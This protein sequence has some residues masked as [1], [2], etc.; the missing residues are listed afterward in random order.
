MNA[1]VSR[2]Q[3]GET[4]IIHRS[5][6]HGADYNPRVIDDAARK[7]LMKAIKQDGLI[8]P[9]V[10]NERTG[11]LVSG[12]QRLGILDQLEKSQDYALSVTV[13]DV[14]ERKEKELNVKFN[15][16]SMQGDWDVEALA[17]LVADDGIGFEE[18]GFTEADAQVLL[19]GDSRLSEMFADTEEVKETKGKLGDIKKERKEATERLKKEQSADFMVTLVCEDRDQKL[20]LCKLLRIPD[21]EQFAVAS[22]LIRRLGGAA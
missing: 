4:R 12:H 11:N 22:D 17:N 6:V 5:E 15:N 2:F 20:A 18:M 16:P 10:W 21:Y 19:G 7:R 9:L 13:I 14:D 3:K 8:G 1:Q